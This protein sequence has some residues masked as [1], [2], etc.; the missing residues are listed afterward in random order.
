MEESEIKKNGC[1]RIAAYIMA[2]I[3]I[4]AGAITIESGDYHC[5]AILHACAPIILCGIALGI[6][7]FFSGRP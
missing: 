7:W 6:F 1:L 4:I 2:M 5:V 3:V